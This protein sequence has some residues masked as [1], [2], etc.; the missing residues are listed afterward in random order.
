MNWQLCALIAFAA[1]GAIGGLTSTLMYQTMVDALNR[2]RPADDQI[3]ATFGSAKDVRWALANASPYWL[4]LKE[5]HRQFPQSRMY[6]WSIAILVSMF[7]M[8]V[9]V[10][11]AMI[12]PHWLQ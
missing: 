4:V 7:A 9:A 2:R 10:A 3:P 5:F 11:L 12:L 6:F 8:F 1:T